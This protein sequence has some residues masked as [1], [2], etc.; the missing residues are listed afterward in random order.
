M[1]I[2]FAHVTYPSHFFSYFDT[3]VLNFLQKFHHH[4]NALL[5]NVNLSISRQPMEKVQPVMAQI[6]P[7]IGDT[8]DSLELEE[9]YLLGYSRL[10]YN[11][12]QC[13]GNNEEFSE[14]MTKMLAQTRI[15]LIRFL[16]S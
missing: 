6:L 13:S 10:L 11:N 9:D 4:Q 1:C 5:A 8:I 12:I 7:L 14:L 3:S 15:L 16:G 2:S